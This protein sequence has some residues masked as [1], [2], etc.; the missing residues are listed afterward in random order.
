MK[1]EKLD[2]QN[3]RN[4]TS[5][6]PAKKERTIIRESRE[7]VEV[8]YQKL[9]NRWFAFS[10]VGEEVYYGEVSQEALMAKNVAIK[11][12]PSVSAIAP[13]AGAT[14][15]IGESTLIA[16]LEGFGDSLTTFVEAMA[17]TDQ[18]KGKA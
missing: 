11:H 12:E 15:D 7:M 18:L 6:A 14:A 17:L 2:S 13:A 5:V 3:Q 8:L 1:H 10:Q 9:G 16:D 4:E